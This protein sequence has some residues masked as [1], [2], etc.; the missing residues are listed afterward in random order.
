M[1]NKKS[2]T[3]LIA[4][5]G[6][7]GRIHE[8]NQRLCNGVPL[9]CYP[10]RLA[11]NCGWFDNIILSTDS[12]VINRLV[13]E[14][15]YGHQPYACH[16]RPAEL[17]TPES[18]VWDAV[19]DALREFK[20]F[21]TDYVVLLT[22]TNPCLR[23]ET[24]T[25][26]CDAFTKNCPH[27]AVV[28]VSY[29]SP[30]TFETGQERWKDFGKKATAERWKDRLCLNNAFFV[31]GWKKLQRGKNIYDDDWGWFDIP[32]DEAIDIDY[33]TDLKM[34]EAVLQWRQRYEKGES[35]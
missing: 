26:A 18:S 22:P 5:K 29:T 2:F 28:S 34:A 6:S 35:T 10:Y 31:S 30:Y 25:L 20:K 19:K 7:S 32:A 11:S 27:K 33:E 9:V 24:L 8:K 16:E 13:M 15:S 3:A 23:H 4:A 21:A 1:L 14:A 17:A 12:D